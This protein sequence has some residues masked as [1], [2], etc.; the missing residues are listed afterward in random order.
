MSD[1]AAA[2]RALLDFF[3]RGNLERAFE[4]AAAVE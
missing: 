1:F 3:D 2:G 4:R